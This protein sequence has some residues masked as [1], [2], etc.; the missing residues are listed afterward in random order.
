[1]SANNF[2]TSGNNLMK[3]FHMTCWGQA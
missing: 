2:G 3:L 1:M